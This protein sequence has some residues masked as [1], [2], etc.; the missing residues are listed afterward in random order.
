MMQNLEFYVCLVFAGLLVVFFLLFMLRMHF[1]VSTGK[2]WLVLL[3]FVAG[4]VAGPWFYTFVSLY[5]P[6]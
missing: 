2:I 3:V 5:A 4:L 6:R 1:G